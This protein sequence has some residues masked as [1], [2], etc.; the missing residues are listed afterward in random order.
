MK[1]KIGDKVQRVEPA[2]DPQ[3]WGIVGQIYTVKF[4]HGYTIELFELPDATASSNAFRYVKPSIFS[5][6]L[7]EL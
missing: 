1:F 2:G 6:D 3:K 4:A 7:F 5:D